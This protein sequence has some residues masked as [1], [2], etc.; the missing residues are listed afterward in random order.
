[1]AKTNNRQKIMADF[2]A[3]YDYDDKLQEIGLSLVEK[4]ISCA[5]LSENDPQRLTVKQL[6]IFRANM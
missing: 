3:R 1:M 6:K 2:H 5:S 4:D